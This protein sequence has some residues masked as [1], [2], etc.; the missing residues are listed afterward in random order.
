[1]SLPLFTGLINKVNEAGVE[2]Y[3]NLINELLKYNIEPMVTLYHSDFPQYL[4]DLGG[5]AN[6]LT[7]DWFEDYARLMFKL[8]GDRVSIAIGKD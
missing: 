6:P 5:W 3:N 2:Y 1:M 8:F 7:V 4:Q